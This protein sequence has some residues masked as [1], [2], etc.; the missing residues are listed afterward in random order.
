MTRD[1]AGHPDGAPSGGLLVIVCGLPGS[2]KTTKA[3]EIAVRRGGLRLGPDEWMTAL[4]VSLWD[5]PMRE[6]VEAL[7]W[8]VAEELLLLGGT[9]IIEWGT[10]A[11]SERD[12]LR[13]RAR[14]LGAAVHLLYLD[15]PDDELW[16]RIHAR[17]REDPPIRRSDI[18][19]W[20]R[21]FEAP[22]E[23]EFGLYDASH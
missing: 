13:R 20:R 7:Q 5:G 2:G 11:R 23:Q 21:H 6:R 9:A 19:G 1:G 12:A 17:A 8:S 22:D 3:K 16:R 15:A 4:G 14:E 18:D 10:W